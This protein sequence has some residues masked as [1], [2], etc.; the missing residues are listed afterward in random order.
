MPCRDAGPGPHRGDSVSGSNKD[1]VSR[2]VEAYNRGAWD[3]LDELVAPDYVHHSNALE[4]TLEQF[5][6]GAGWLRDGMPD[7]SATVM[8]LVAEGDRVVARWIARGTH[9]HSMAGEAP[10]SRAVTLHGITLYRIRDG[11][12]AEDW[13]AMDERD[14][15]RQI[16]AVGG[17]T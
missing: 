15:M 9:L 14:L 3:E 13:E 8:D 16:G 4:L 17:E 6:R 5:K 12:I 2:Y 10:T 7:F 11:L 1:L